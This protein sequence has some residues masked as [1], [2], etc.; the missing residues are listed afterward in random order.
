M[1]ELPEVETIKNILAP[2]VINKTIS[3]FELYYPNVIKS[4]IDDFRKNILN[5]TI[6]NLTRYGKYLFFHLSS[7]YILISHLRMEGKWRYTN[8]LNKRIKSTSITFNFKDNTSLSFDDTRKFGIL[9]LAKESEYLN[10]KM[11][12]KL[13]IEANK[14]EDK[15]IKNIYPKFMKN[16]PIKTLLTDQSIIS[17]IGNIYADETL[18]ISSINPLTKGKELSI[19]EIS[20]LLI[21]AKNILNKAIELGGSTVHSYHPSEGIDGK[22]QEE[23]KCYGK[24]GKLCP[25]CGTTFH[26]IFLNG[27]GTTYCPNCQ[28]DKSLKKAIGITGPIGSGKS[29][30]LEHFKDIDYLTL[31]SDQLIHELYRNIVH[32]NKIS[33]ILNINFDIDNEKSKNLA[34]QIMVKY[35]SKKKE[36]EDYIYPHLENLLIKY[37]KENDNIAIEVPLLFKA[38]YEY[39]FK[40]IIVL[41]IDKEKQI[42][43]LISRGEKNIELISKLNSDFSYNKNFKDLIIIKN[44]SSKEELFKKVDEIL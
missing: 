12:K 37:I 17:G 9:Y 20:N 8:S 18:F 13:G 24:E 29:M 39:L 5:K 1:P 6:I 14:I 34:K 28:I 3:S 26:K 23:L 27:R 4:N 22:F 42:E 15:D 19:D 2:L 35:P 36:V 32:K 44:N 31:N 25:R 10:L 16:K 40:K 33:K 38:H 21:N 43:N 7:D 11:I 30:L 41:E